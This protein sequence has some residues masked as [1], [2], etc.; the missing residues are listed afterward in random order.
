MYKNCVFNIG[1]V[2]QPPISE[3]KCDDASHATD[4]DGIHS[5]GPGIAT[6]NHLFQKIDF[7]KWHEMYQASKERANSAK[8]AAKKE[9][10]EK[11]AYGGFLNLPCLIKQIWL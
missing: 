8:D 5:Y 9:A 3:K 11:E 2:S 6:N 4:E 1:A 7:S 10:A